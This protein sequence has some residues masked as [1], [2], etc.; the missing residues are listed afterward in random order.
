MHD[1]LHP[2]YLSY[3]AIGYERGLVRTQVRPVFFLHTHASSK[4]VPRNPSNPDSLFDRGLI[5]KLPT[6]K[7]RPKK[8]RVTFKEHL[9]THR[10][11]VP[12]WSSWIIGSRT[13]HDVGMMK[14]L[15]G[16]TRF[17]KRRAYSRSIWKRYRAQGQK[18]MSIGLLP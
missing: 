6:V 3:K 2:L 16:P 11:R 9:F 10:S 18:I 17:K 1:R 13:H 12:S 4:C 5:A 7:Y 14:S 8:R 15:P